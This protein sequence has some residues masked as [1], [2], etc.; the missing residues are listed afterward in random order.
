VTEPSGRKKLIAAGTKLFAERGFAGASVRDIAREAGVSIGLIRSH[1]GSKEGL[2]TEIEAH[3]AEQVEALYSTVV[4]HSGS[5]ALERVVEDAVE[6][7][8]RDRDAL[9]YLRTA[10]MEKTPGSQKMFERLLATLRRFVKQNR[11]QGFLQEGV[12]EEWA[13]IYLVFDFLGPA[14][15]EPFAEEAFGASMYARPMVERRNAFGRRL[16]TRGFLKA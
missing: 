12:D 16:L 6:W 5:R 8:E 1:F 3:V 14:L 15:I 2:R 9:L 13:V 10:L 7:I 11:E 4:E